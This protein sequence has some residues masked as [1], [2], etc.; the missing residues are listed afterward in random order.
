MAGLSI[1]VTERRRA[2]KA[3]QESERRY[4]DLFSSISDWICTH[5]LEGRLLSVNPSAA[6][7]LGYEAEEL[8]GLP[9]IDLLEPELRSDFHEAYL[10]EI[11]SRGWAR[12]IVKYQARNGEKYYI[13]YRN[14]LVR[15]DGREPYVSAVGRDITE[16]VLAEREFKKLQQQL[17]QAQ[18][19]EAIGTLAGGI[20]HDFNNI[21]YAIIGYT[22]LALDRLEDAKKAKNDLREVLR[23]SD[24][25]KNLVQQILNFSRQTDQSRSPVKLSPIIKE[26]LKL[27][28]ATLPTTIE[29]KWEINDELGA[30]LADPVQIHQVLMNLCANAGHAMADQEGVLTVGL[31]QVQ[32]DE[33]T[34]AR[35]PD[36]KMGPYLK[37]TVG[38]SGQG[39]DPQT[40]E[41]IFEPFFTTK[42]QGQGTGMGLAVVHGIVKSHHGAIT[43]SSRPGRGSVFEV[44]LPLV[45]PPPAE[46]PVVKEENIPRGTERLLVVDDEEP[47]AELVQQAFERLGYQAVM[48]TDSLEALRWIQEDPDRFDLIITD[49][50]MPHLTGDRLAEAA[51][52]I[53]PELPIIICTGFSRRLSP[54]KA[55]RIGIRRLIMKPLI[56]AEMARQVREV[57]EEDAP[58]PEPKLK[59]R[60]PLRSGQR[61]ER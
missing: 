55:K 51:L 19:M 11:E 34:A 33:F 59:Y 20:A 5:N 6:D 46:E 54:A 29:I 52:K 35:N 31:D 49:Q 44:F 37:L 40:M 9:M 27:L 21:L 14:T 57:L 12:G 24:R 13:E 39:M 15:Q 7:A 61:G 1:D 23:A 47:L 28:R 43:V 4:S 22:E 16:R 48:T 8:I 45:E 30:V 38:D 17:N 25:A 50:T 36:L 2:I 60:P 10:K 53:R 3:L 18:K 32:V 41:R 58:S 42:D 26:T 56:I